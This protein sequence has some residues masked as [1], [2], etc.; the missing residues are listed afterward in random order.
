MWQVWQAVNAH[1]LFYQLF[2]HPAKG[3][4][5]KKVVITDKVVFESEKDLWHL[6]NNRHLL[7]RV[8]SSLIPWSYFAEGQH[9]I[10]CPFHHDNTPSAKIYPNDEDGIEKLFCFSCNRAFWTYEYVVKCSRLDPYKELLENCSMEEIISMAN[11]Q[12]GMEDEKPDYLKEYKSV[13]KEQGGDIA[14]YIRKSYPEE[15]VVSDF[16]EFWGKIPKITDMKDS[17][18]R[19][20]RIFALKR[21]LSVGLAS[22]KTHLLD[23]PR[24]ENYYELLQ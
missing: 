3:R 12:Q 16:K 6:R 5:E 19:N 23:L 7:K 13:F 24:H 1:I 17:K 21:G 8:F 15:G 4:K 9:K 11:T 10:L 2:Q 22:S 14:S 18:D 20:H